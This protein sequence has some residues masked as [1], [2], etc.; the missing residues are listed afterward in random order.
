MIKFKCYSLTYV[1]FPLVLLLSFGISCKRIAPK[2]IDKE[3]YIP[4][5]DNSLYMRL[6]GNANGPIIVMLHGGPGGT[7]GFD[8]EFY[9]DPMEE[10]YL[11]A[12]LDQRG[13]GKSPREKN[14]SLITM[15]Q[16]VADLDA[17]IDT[18]H[19]QYPDQ[20]IHLLGGSWGG[21]YGFLYLLAHQD[22]IRSFICVSGKVDGPY[23]NKVLIDHEM[24]LVA[25]ELNAMED[26]TSATADTLRQIALE[27]KRIANSDFD[28]FFKDVELLKFKFPKKLGFNAYW[29]DSVAHNKAVQL[30]KDSAFYARAHY[31]MASYDSVTEKGT[32]VNQVFRN[33]PAY[34]RI[35][36]TGRLAEIHVPVAVIG[37]AEDYVVG[38][39]H[40]NLIYEALT[41]LNQNQ[42]ELH[43]MA[44]AAHNVN[45]EAADA[46]Y[47]IV[48]AF[49]AK[50]P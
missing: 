50:H 40:A 33:T 37:G 22:K 26:T 43:I 17:V 44:G 39:G 42:K 19:H 41:G 3:V 16:F 38:P 45:M 25:S 36:L 23:E 31:D 14:D 11:M 15:A 32:H 34:N 6:S 9:K 46:Y 20:S 35:Q 18:L 47:P 49:L 13:C 21:T 27:L 10:Q 30:G 2:L 4:V 24:A 5:K 8:R 29:Y 12:Y 48:K 7:S 28:R 1:L